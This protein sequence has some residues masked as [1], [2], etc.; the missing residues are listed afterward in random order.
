MQMDDAA[1]RKLVEGEIRAKATRRVRAKIG[2]IWHASIYAMVSCALIAINNAYTPGN[3]WFV[4]PVAAWGAAVAL[5]GL[6]TM[7][8]AGDSTEDMIEAEIA[9]E[10]ARRGIS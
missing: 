8:I 10:K 1:I 3:N 2:L 9:K 6:A 4:W 5:H 7:Q